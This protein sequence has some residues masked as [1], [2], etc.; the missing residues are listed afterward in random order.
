[1]ADLTLPL[2]IMNASYGLCILAWNPVIPILIET[3]S[4]LILTRSI[5]QETFLP[6]LG[7]GL[8]ALYFMRLYKNDYKASVETTTLVKIT[9]C[10]IWYLQRTFIIVIS[11]VIAPLIKPLPLYIFLNL[12][13]SYPFLFDSGPKRRR[14]EA[15]LYVTLSYNVGFALIRH[16]QGDVG[17]SLEM[18]LI[19][20]IGIPLALLIYQDYANKK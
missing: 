3:L 1:M 17:Q 11:P 6:R 9:G 5:D 18:Q 14:W 8:W 13:M 16:L 15:Y 2:T 12:I 10:L 4:W 19:Q 20:M 7:S